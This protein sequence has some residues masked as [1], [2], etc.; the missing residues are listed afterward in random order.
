MTSLRLV[1]G[2]QLTR[3]LASLQDIDKARDVVLMAE[4]HDETTYVPH[5]KQ[6][7]VLVLSAMRHFA[8]ELRAEGIHVDY[9]KLSDNNNTGSFAGEIERAITRH[10]P[11][12]IVL[13]EPGEWRVL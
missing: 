11:S 13:T 4:V 6:K 2:D 12:Q 5:H 10:T 7:I 3:D 9:V 8:D 1:L